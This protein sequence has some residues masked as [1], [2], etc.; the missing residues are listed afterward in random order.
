MFGIRMSLLVKHIGWRPF[1]FRLMGRY[2]SRKISPYFP[3]TS[4]PAFILIK[5]SC[6]VL[7]SIV[8]VCPRQIIVNLLFILNVILTNLWSLPMSAFV[9]TSQFVTIPLG[10]S[11]QHVSGFLFLHLVTSKSTICFLASE[12]AYL[13]WLV[14]VPMQIQLSDP[15]FHFSPLFQM[16]P[17]FWSLL[18]F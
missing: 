1:F 9:I 4:Y 5:T 15:L 10:Y 14:C 8:I 3:K 7:F 13:L 16:L 6:F 17:C 2:L 11:R 18:L 12:I